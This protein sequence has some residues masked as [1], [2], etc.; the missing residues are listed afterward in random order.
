M[1]GNVA[2]LLLPAVVSPTQ[3]PTKLPAGMSARFRV[4]TALATACQEAGY[5]SDIGYNT[6]LYSNETETRSLLMWCVGGGGSHH[7]T[8]SLH[9]TISHHLTISVHLSYLLVPPARLVERLPKEAAEASDE[10][11]GEC[12]A[13]RGVWGCLHCSLRDDRHWC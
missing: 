13:G 4:G 9:R 3:L 5:G 11:L 12:D 10:V 6:F 2:E 8:I 1:V 7:L